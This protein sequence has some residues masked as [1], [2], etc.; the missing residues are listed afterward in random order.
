MY[1]NTKMM[2]T[3]TIPGMGGRGNQGMMEGVNSNMIYLIQ[4]LL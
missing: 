1:V 3:E 4:E 2:P